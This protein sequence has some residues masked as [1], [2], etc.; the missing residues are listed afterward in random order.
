MAFR[1]EMMHSDTHR[2]TIWPEIRQTF[3]HRRINLP[4]NVNQTLRC[5]SEANIAFNEGRKH[6]LMYIRSGSKATIFTLSFSF[7]V[8][9]FIT[10]PTVGRKVELMEKKILGVQ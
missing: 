5:V 9:N 8:Q 3:M 1:W 4:F 6:S 10:L 2:N 7:F